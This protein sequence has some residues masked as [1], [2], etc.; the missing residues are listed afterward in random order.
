MTMR[1]PQLAATAALA[2]AAAL[3]AAPAAAQPI[4]SAGVRAQGMAG[5]FVAVADDASAVY[6]NPAALAKGPFFGAVLEQ[7]SGDL[8]PS[9]AQG[10]PDTASRSATLV[11][12]SVPS[13]GVSYFRSRLVRAPAADAVAHSSRIDG[14]AGGSEVSSLTTHQ[15]GATILQSLADNVI[16]GTTLKWVRGVAAAG[17]LDAEAA[18]GGRLDQARALDGRAGDAFDFDLGLLAIVKTVRLGLVAKNLRAPVFEA[19]DGTRLGLEQQVRV[20][21]AVP[22][23]AAALVAAD[24]DLRRTTDV[25]GTRRR[26]VSLGTE[27]RVNAYLVVRGGV[28][29]AVAGGSRAA[30]AGGAS[31]ALGRLWIDGQVCRGQHGDQGWSVG[32]RLQY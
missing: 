13:L 29:F 16:V 26:R 20:G 25:D 6:W 5:A 18:N 24:V 10:V 22:L 32:I 9:G 14:G 23:G 1:I 15:L 28:G 11:A 3:A 30:A 7:A 2:V 17:P 8:D 21:V 4:E 12:V 19:P 27:G 31:V